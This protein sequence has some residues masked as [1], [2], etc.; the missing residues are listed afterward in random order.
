L[1]KKD[2]LIRLSVRLT[3]EGKVKRVRLLESTGDK[4][5]DKKLEAAF[6]EKQLQKPPLELVAR[7]VRIR[8]SSRL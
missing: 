4:A 5:V 2:Y 6:T 7:P 3:K 8:T 1:R